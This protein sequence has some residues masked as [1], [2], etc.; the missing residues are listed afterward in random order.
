MIDATHA[1]AMRSIMDQIRQFEQ[2]ASGGIAPPG[3]PAPRLVEPAAPGPVGFGG[4][5]RNA[6]ESVN[7][8]QNDARVAADAYERGEELP[9]TDV[10]LAMQKASVAFEAT[11]QVRNQ[12]MKAYEDIRNMPI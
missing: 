12:V 3:A 8:L 11:L 7:A 1:S 10:V 4:M 5:L 2:R 6:V 9:L